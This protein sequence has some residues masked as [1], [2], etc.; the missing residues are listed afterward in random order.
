MTLEIQK[1]SKLQTLPEKKRWLIE[2]L[3]SHEA[4][5]IIGG[6]PKSYKS[7]LALSMA[8]AVASGKPC[9]GRY[10]VSHPG[11][12]LLFAAEDALHIVRSRLEGICHHNHIDFE[13]LELW[14]ITTPKIRL[15]HKEDCKQLYQT[16]KQVRPRLLILDP[17]VRLHNVDENQ[18]A[19]I[20]PLLAFLRDIQRNMGCAVAL[21]HHA[22]K[23][24]SSRAGQALRGSSEIHAWGDSNLYLRRKRG[25]LSLTIEHRA[26]ASHDN[27]PL[28]LKNEGPSIALE[29][30]KNETSLNAVNPP[31]SEKYR[32]LEALKS[33]HNPVRQR[34][35][36][37][38]CRIRS[39]SLSHR[40]RELVNNGEVIRTQDGWIL[41]AYYSNLDNITSS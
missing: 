34:V 9:L 29:I 12:V 11:K 4:V 19:A 16:V 6:E 27:I 7:F 25:G 8:V 32:I 23:S 40:L 21:V 26:Q 5:G 39:E 28:T 30:D 13:S 17:L 35:L 37:D 10:T 1:A 36:R 31:I 3:W 41:S 2:S 38:T 15:D 20:V 24:H 18:V 14:V 33:F 22:R